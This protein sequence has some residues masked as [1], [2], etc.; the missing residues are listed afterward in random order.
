MA[1]PAGYYCHLVT[2]L[3]KVVSQQA[4]T[5][6][7]KE[8]PQVVKTDQF[9]RVTALSASEQLK[10][11]GQVQVG[12]HRVEM[13]YRKD[14]TNKHQLRWQDTGTLLDI[15]GFMPKPNENEIEFLC[16]SVT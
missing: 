15:T 9:A 4:R 3:Q 2:V 14:I 8:T 12:L 11:T 6:A 13:A 5:G 1:K 16:T 10:A 7:P